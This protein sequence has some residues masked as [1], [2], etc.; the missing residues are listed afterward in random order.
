MKIHWLTALPLFAFAPSSLAQAL[1]GLGDHEGAAGEFPV[2]SVRFEVDDDF[3]PA[4]PGWG[5]TRFDRIGDALEEIP[6]DG[7]VFVH[8]GVYEL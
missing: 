1:R 6:T 8:S 2:R 3:G 7:I 4:T 5:R